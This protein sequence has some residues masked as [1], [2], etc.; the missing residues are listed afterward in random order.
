MLIVGGVPVLFVG[1]LSHLPPQPPFLLRE[2]GVE[3]APPPSLVLDSLRVAYTSVVHR[4]LL[5]Y[6]S[7]DPSYEYTS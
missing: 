1:L 5:P 4:P 6:L 3:P 7:I 2:P